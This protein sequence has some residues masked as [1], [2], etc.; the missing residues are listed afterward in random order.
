[1]LTITELQQR[2]ENVVQEVEALRE[3]LV[4]AFALTD[5]DPNMSLVRTGTVLE[6]MIH[7]LYKRHVGEPGTQPQEALLQKLLKQES[8]PRDFEGYAD[9]VRK[10]R[11]GALHRGARY[12][13]EDVYRALIN[14]F[15]IVEWYVQTG[16]KGVQLQTMESRDDITRDALKAKSRLHLGAVSDQ[17]TNTGRREGK[18]ED[19]SGDLHAGN[20]RAPEDKDKKPSAPS[21]EAPAKLPS[22]SSTISS[23]LTPSLRAKDADGSAANDPLLRESPPGQFF[24]YRTGKVVMKDGTTLDFNGFRALYSNRLHYTTNPQDQDYTAFPTV[25]LDAIS[26]IDFTDESRSVAA[27]GELF[28]GSIRLASVQLR[29]GKVLK[30]LRV[31]ARD[32]QWADFESEGFG[33]EQPIMQGHLSDSNI[34]AVVFRVSSNPAHAEPDENAT[35][36][37]GPP[38]RKPSATEIEITDVQGRRVALT[39][40]RIL[41]PSTFGPSPEKRGISVRRGVE[42]GM[43]EWSRVSSMAFKSQKGKNAKGTEIWRYEIVAILHNGNQ[44][45]GE[46]VEDWNMAYMGGGGTGLLLGDTDLGETKIRFCDIQCIQV[47]SARE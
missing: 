18:P 37:E 4:R 14:L 36:S 43:I 20:G 27:L 9:A 34:A 25:D 31:A 33:T 30:N 6:T 3:G 29:N 19:R 39:N 24:H 47:I 11:N 41:Y 5:S 16:S 42:E 7:D 44:L 28:R 10:L 22:Q 21:I 32:C 2:L 38:G 12:S 17:A 8:F 40:P 1:M 46:V 45:N 23:P 26:R 13:S 35:A 15:P